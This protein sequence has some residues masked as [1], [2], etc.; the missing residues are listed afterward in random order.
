MIRSFL[1]II[2]AC[3]LFYLG[4]EFHNLANGTPWNIKL[5]DYLPALT[6]LLAAFLGAGYAFKLQ[7]NKIARDQ[8]K[9]HV[10]AGNKA[11]FML[12]RQYNELSVIQRQF[13]DP[14]R[15]HPF[16]FILMRAIISH[17]VD[18]FRFNENELSFLLQTK[19]R[20]LLTLL[21]IEESSFHTTIATLNDRTK[22]HMEEV[23][24]SLEAAGFIDG[25]EVTMEA[26]KEALGDR[27]FTYLQGAT[28]NVINNVDLGVN[29]LHEM[30]QKLNEALVELYPDEEFIAFK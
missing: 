13:I 15:D 29:A 1:E 20:Q 7:N 17:S 21:F 3:V 28:D 25:E 12:L 10:A 18:H 11:I 19:H 6:T 30:G 2:G 22:K 16:K 9:E 8:V 26:Y 23:Q 24:P 14:I 27:L 4:V 5:L